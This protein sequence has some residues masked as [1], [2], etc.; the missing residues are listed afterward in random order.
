MLPSPYFRVHLL[1]VQRWIGTLFP[2]TICPFG[3]LVP[4]SK[5]SASLAR[6]TTDDLNRCLDAGVNSTNGAPGKVYTCYSGASQQRWYLTGDNHIAVTGGN[7]C[8]D[9]K[10]GTDEFQTWQC[11]SG[12]TNQ[13]FSMTESPSADTT[14]LQGQ[15]RI[16]YPRE[17]ADLNA[18][19]RA[20]DLPGTFRFQ[21]CSAHYYKEGSRSIAV[22]HTT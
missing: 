4:I 13:V 19:V 2:A 18:L 16:A 5:G 17:G 7:Q 22:S 3:S 9:R 21:Y 15:Q 14:C 20:S 11:S 1:A 8:L 6:N 10:S 12:S